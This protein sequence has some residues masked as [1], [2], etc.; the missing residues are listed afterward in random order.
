MAKQII[1]DIFFLG[2]SSESA[3]KVDSQVEKNL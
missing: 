1:K 3:T 2:Q